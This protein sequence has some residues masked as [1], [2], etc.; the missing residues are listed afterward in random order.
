MSSKRKTLEETVAAL[1][2]RFGPNAI[3]TASSKAKVSCVSTGFRKLDQA[4]DGMA[5]IPRGHITEI[6][7]MPTSGMTTL[8]LKI[9]ANAQAGG[10]EAAYVDLGA[11]FDPDYAA[12]CDVQLNKLLLVRPPSGQEALQ[13]MQSLIV[14]R[15]VGI[16]VFDAAPQLLSEPQGAARMST[17][18]RRL[19]RSLSGSPC[20]LIFLTPLYFG[21]A[22][23]LAH[24]PSGFALP[25][26]AALRLLLKKEYWLYRQKNINGYQAQAE[27]IKNQFGRSGK[28]AT[29]RITFNGVVRNDGT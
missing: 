4:L 3:K 24:Y 21:D 2:L 23:S 28:R 6:L 7:G 17:A 29:I 12:R 25:H 13:I 10:D 22:H 8:A 1:R 19:I 11:T 20:A 16:L 18:L 15:G 14:A 26:Y 5:G 27:V 9:I